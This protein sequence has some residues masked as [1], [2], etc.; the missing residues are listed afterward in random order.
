MFQREMVTADFDRPAGEVWY[1]RLRGGGEQ[2]P[3]ELT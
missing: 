3:L 2:Q 1:S